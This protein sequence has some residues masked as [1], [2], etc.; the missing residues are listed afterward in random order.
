MTK[1]F[2]LIATIL[3][4]FSSYAYQTTQE[5]N[6]AESEGFTNKITLSSEIKWEKMNPARGDQSPLAGT[7]WGDRKADVATG[8]I[9]KFKDGF[10]SPPHIHNVT[11]RA[12]VMNGLIHNDDLEAERMWMPTGSFWTQPAGASHITAAKGKATMAYIEIDHGPYLVK[13]VEES[14]QNNERPLNL[15]ISNVVWLDHTATHWISENSLAQLSFL[16]K[17]SQNV[18]GI[19]IHLPENYHGEILSDGEVFTGIVISGN[20]GYQMPGENALTQLDRGSSFSSTTRSSHKINTTAEVL[21]YIRTNAK[22]E[23]R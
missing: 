10:S 1:I 22:F 18:Q 12:I 13:P 15:D 11:Y 19:L 5:K 7:I 14:F 17:N 16:W 8:Y 4:G 9:G 23:I 21:L 3:F 20:I 2:I 6:R